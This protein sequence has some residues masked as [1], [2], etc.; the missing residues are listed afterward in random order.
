MAQQFSVPRKHLT[1][2][3]M[4]NASQRPEGQRPDC[5]WDGVDSSSK[6]TNSSTCHPGNWNEKW[7]M[8]VSIGSI[9]NFLLELPVSAVAVFQWGGTSGYSSKGAVLYPCQLF[10]RQVLTKQW[11]WKNQRPTPEEEKQKRLERTAGGAVLR[12]GQRFGLWVK[13][14]GTFSGRISNPL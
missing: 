5:F 1:S 10:L 8:G 7:Y 9:G 11:S 14:S 12:V 2:K 13:T 4:G 6:G 3:A